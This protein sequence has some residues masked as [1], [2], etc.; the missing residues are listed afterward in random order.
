MKLLFDFIPLAL[1]F[2][3]F[4]WAQTAPTQ[5]AEWATRY[6]GFAVTGGV[7]GESQAPVLWAT[8][9]AMAATLAQV[10]VQLLARRRVSAVLWLS[11]GVIVVMGG[12]TIWFNSEV[13][14]KWKPTLLYVVFAAILAGGH[15]FGKKNFL[16]QLLG[17]EIVLPA[18]VW[19][20]LLALWI[21]FFVG[22]AV[23]NL[24]V[25]YTVDTAT[26]VNFKVFGLIALT[27]LFTLGQGFYMARHMIE[28]G[29]ENPVVKP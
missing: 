17:R 24:L 16:R 4:K 15:L 20:R 9:V 5:A 19:T 14:I 1:F 6:L 18:A 27:L 11:L 2:A 25:A 12:L 29:P 7:V 23:L 26:W 28:P 3:V 13:F 10:T 8:L 21:A 22:V